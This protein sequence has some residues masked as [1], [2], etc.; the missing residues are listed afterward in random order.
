M[1]EGTARILMLSPI[2]GVLSLGALAEPSKLTAGMGHDLAQRICSSCHLIEP[3][4]TNPPD[5]VGGPSFQTVADRPDTT[6]ATLDHHLR[7]TKHS[8]IVPLSM[9]N[10]K[11]TPDQEN[12]VVDYILSLRQAQK[13]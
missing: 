9:P 8:R 4:Q 13:P 1:T 5:H 2:L 11:L 10:P 6:E 12:K 3:G 7:T